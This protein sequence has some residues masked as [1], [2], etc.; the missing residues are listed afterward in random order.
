MFVQLVHIRIK[1]DR[2]A[3]FL[4]VFRRNYDGTRREPGNIRFDVLQE[5]EEP[6]HFAI[7]EVFEDAAAVE[8]H[9]AT[10]HYREVAA[11]LEEL[12][13]GPRSKEYYTLLLPGRDELGR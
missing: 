10:A 12:M 3:E 4:E 11:R 5:P 13:E 6:T 2:I 8:A 7:Y 1:P 9:R